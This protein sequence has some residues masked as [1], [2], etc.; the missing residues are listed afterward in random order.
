MHKILKEILTKTQADI[1]KFKQSVNTFS[2]ALTNPKSGS[3][4]IIAEIKL[5]SPTAKNLGQPAKVKD[6]AKEYELAGADCISVVVEKHFFHGDPKFIKEIKQT[7]SL[8]VLCKDFIIDSYQVYQVKQLGADA[9]LLVARIVSEKQL[10]TLVN[11][12]KEIGIE[13]VVEINSQGDFEKTLKTNTQII[14]VNARNLDTFEVNIDKACQLLKIIP[15]TF[16]KLGFSGIITRE[17]VLKYQK[18]GVNGVLIGTSL[19]K[20]KNIDEY[21]KGILS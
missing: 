7:V 18:A 2:K 20:T 15:N 16:I 3:T 21:L 17:D 13:S 12:A 9:I 6:K 1:R 10:V 5:A 14:A 8:P 11:L 19:M 4:A